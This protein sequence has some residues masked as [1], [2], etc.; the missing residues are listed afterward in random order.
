MVRDSIE[1]HTW[2]NFVCYLKIFQEEVWDVQTSHLL[3][4]S[5]NWIQVRPKPKNQTQQLLFVDMVILLPFVQTRVSRKHSGRMNITKMTDTLSPQLEVRIRWTRRQ[6]GVFK[7]QLVFSSNP[8]V[9]YQL[10]NIMH[11]LNTALICMV[12]KRLCNVSL[13][14]F[15]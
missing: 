5:E 4:K 10:F 14:L 15:F 1:K 7:S 8:V 12:S 9:Q 3:K 6:D 2:I 13:R 11:H